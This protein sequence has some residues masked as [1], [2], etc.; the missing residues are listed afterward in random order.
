[1]GVHRAG[2]W[3]AWT[4]LST[5]L[6]GQMQLQTRCRMPR[7]WLIMITLSRVIRPSD[8]ALRALL[9]PQEVT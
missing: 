5:G 1:M 9:A 3:A 4:V 6:V 7:Q 8:E 2:Q